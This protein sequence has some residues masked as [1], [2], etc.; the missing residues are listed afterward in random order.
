MEIVEYYSCSENRKF[1]DQIELC[2]W[3]AAKYLAALLK[4]NR[5]AAELGGWAKLFL[6]TDVSII[7]KY[8][9]NCKYYQMSECLLFLFW[10]A[11]KIKQGNG[12]IGVFQQENIH[13][14]TAEFVDS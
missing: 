6:L 13:M 8:K 4:E 2:E 9:R 1:L 14:Q 7:R 5:L 10:K 11:Y 3:R 12:S